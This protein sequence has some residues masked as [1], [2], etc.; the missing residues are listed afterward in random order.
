MRACGILRRFQQ[1]FSY[2]KTLLIECCMRRDSARCVGDGNTDDTVHQTHDTI[3]SLSHIILTQVLQEHLPILQ[4]TCMLT[5]I[6]YNLSTKKGPY[7]T[8][9][10]F[11]FLILC[12]AIPIYGILTKADRVDNREDELSTA[13]IEE[14]F[15]ACLGLTG[16]NCYCSF[17]TG[18][19]G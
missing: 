13:T 9:M 11:L 19:A 15:L 14:D 8:V 10:H 12:L 6:S 18:C 1:S 5:T 4:I 16:N 2:I 3:T 17:Y 7:F